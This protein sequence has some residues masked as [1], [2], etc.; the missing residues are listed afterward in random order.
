MQPV[1]NEITSVKHNPKRTGLQAKN[2]FERVKT[3]AMA[4]A[5]S[6]TAK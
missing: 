1:F 5:K 4:K 6:T 3:K 2:W